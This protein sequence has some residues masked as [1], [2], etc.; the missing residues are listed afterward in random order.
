VRALVRMLSVIVVV[1]VAML[2]PRAARGDESLDACSSAAV[3]GQKLRR[4]GKLREAKS[5]FETCSRSTCREDIVSD[6]KAWQDEVARL[7]PSV[8]IQAHDADGHPVTDARVR[9]DGAPTPPEA[10]SQPIALDPGQH[11][12]ELERSGTSPISRSIVLREGERADVSVIFASA[13]A[14]TAAPPDA[15]PVPTSVWVSGAVAAAGLIGFGVLAGVG[16]ADW[17]DS[18]CDVS[19]VP[20]DAERVR[21]TLLAADVSLAIGAIASGVATWL[22]LTRPSRTSATMASKP[23]ASDVLFRF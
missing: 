3:N 8:V 2:A 1:G 23:A 11:T 19:C 21:T 7:L 14:P 4:D 18:R 10:L 17:N 16:Y 6:C 15:R 5:W 20:A 9:I 12:V 22:Y 13:R